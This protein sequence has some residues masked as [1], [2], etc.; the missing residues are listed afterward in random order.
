[1]VTRPHAETA[2]T[3]VVRRPNFRGRRNNLSAPREVGSRYQ[4]EYFIQSRIGLFKQKEHGLRDFLQ[5]VRRNFGC[6]PY[7][8]AACAVQQNQ[9]EFCGQYRRFFQ[10]TV[11]VGNEF[12]VVAVQFVQ[13]KPRQFHQPRFGV[14]HRRGSVPVAAAE[15]ALT[16]HQGVTHRKRLRHAYHGVVRGLI[17]MRMVFTQH[18]THDARRLRVAIRGRQVHALHGV[19]NAALHGL[20]PV[21]NV[22]QRAALHD[23]QG[24]FQVGARRVMRKRQR[25][26]VPVLR[27]KLARKCLGKPTF[28]DRRQRRFDR[29]LFFRRFNVQNY[30]FGRRRFRFQKRFR[31]KE[32]RRIGH[33]F[34]HSVVTPTRHV[35]LKSFGRNRR[36]FHSFS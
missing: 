28:G 36:T 20:H 5:V 29:F 2:A 19:Q 24:I 26:A 11:V 25:L 4:R 8:D 18:F 35:F 15:I 3:G 27:R 22:R 13:K 23:R 21:Y 9:R 7:G 12:D 10:G 16:V 17:P 6:H 32:F 30:G 33:G 34:R 1:M 31:R 14:T